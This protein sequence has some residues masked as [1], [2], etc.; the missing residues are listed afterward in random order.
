MYKIN[1][2]FGKD[3]LIELSDTLLDTHGNAKSIVEKIRNELLKTDNIL[4]NLKQ[5]TE[6]QFS[7]W[8]DTGGSYTKAE[9][10]AHKISKLLFGKVI[11]RFDMPE[12]HG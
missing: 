6:N 4:P 10:V 11:K 9:K 7:K 5:P 1:R 12:N 2:D 3:K 8:C